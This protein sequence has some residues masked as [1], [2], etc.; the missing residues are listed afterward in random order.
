[1]SNASFPPIGGYLPLELQ[2][3]NELRRPNAY[4][5][6]LGRAG[7]RLI[8]EQREY[9]RV[10]LPAY[11]CPVVFETLDKIGVEYAFYPI[12][13]TLNPIFDRAL[14]PDE[15]FLAVDYFG[16]K[17][18]MISTLSYDERFRGR[19]V[20]D[21]TQA[22]F[23]HRK[24]ASTRLIRLGNLSASRTADSFSVISFLSS[25]CRDARR[26]IVAFTC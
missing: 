18:K 4:P 5:V 3:T 19:L 13:A 6:D 10:W 2:A 11:I 14:E 25:T 26:L 12:D 1:M 9:R 24:L 15:A 22:F 8:V 16:V 20:A 17:D 21:L 7:L 23:T